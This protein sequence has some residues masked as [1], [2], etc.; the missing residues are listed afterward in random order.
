METQITFALPMPFCSASGPPFI[1]L[2][3][4]ASPGFD[5]SSISIPLVN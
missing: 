3:D 1:G 5:P 2:A 4:A